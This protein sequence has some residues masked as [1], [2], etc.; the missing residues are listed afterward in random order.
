MTVDKKSR[1]APSLLSAM[2]FILAVF[3]ITLFGSGVTYGLN[4]SGNIGSNETWYA[5]DNPHVVT[6][7]IQVHNNATL[8]IEPGCV[9]RF[10]PGTTLYFG[11]SSGAAL[12]AVGTSVNPITFTSNAASPAPGDWRGILFFNHT[13]DAETIMDYCT[14][15]Y[16]GNGGE[17]SNIFCT[18]ASPTI[19]NCTMRYSD[20]Y[21]MSFGSND[22]DG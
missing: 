11:Y 5:A 3:I 13:D 8:T 12:K 18:E 15:E 16:G 1:T 22:L 10:F 14:V 21:A 20:G 9:V 2:V 4:H 17:N 7:S 19:Q 6:A